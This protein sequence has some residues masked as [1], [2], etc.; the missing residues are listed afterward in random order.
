[1][2]L[3]DEHS[4]NDPLR[5]VRVELADFPRRWMHHCLL[6]G[7]VPEDSEAAILY[8][9]GSKRFRIVHTNT[10]PVGVQHTALKQI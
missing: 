2:A 7:L 9:S 6:V 10:V 8:E 4:A 5:A 3:C 1:M